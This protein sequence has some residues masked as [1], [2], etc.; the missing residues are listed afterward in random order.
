MATKATKTHLLEPA[1]TPS[2]GP[3]QQLDFTITVTPRVVDLCGAQKDDNS[4]PQ[5]LSSASVSQLSIHLSASKLQ[6]I[7]TFVEVLIKKSPD[8][9]ETPDLTSGALSTEDEIAN[10]SYFVRTLM[11]EA[12]ATEAIG[13]TTGENASQGFWAAVKAAARYV[14][15]Q[16]IQD[17]GGMIEG[18]ADYFR[19]VFQSVGGLAYAGYRGVMIPADIQKIDTS[20][21]A[22]TPLGQSAYILG[23]IGNIAFL[24]FYLAIG[25]WSGYSLTE[26]FRFSAAMK[27]QEKTG[28]LFD[29]FM[30]KVT[31]DPKTKLQ[32][33]GAD[34][35]Q[36]T[37]FKDKLADVALS[38]FANQFLKWQDE[39]IKEGKLKEKP[40]TEQQVK[41]VFKE[42]FKLQEAELRNQ[43]VHTTYLKA[44]G[45]DNNNLGDLNFT[46]LELIG[47]KLEQIR[48]QA[49]KEV[50]FS[51]A[52]NGDCVEA[53]KKAAKRGLGERL[54]CN[55]DA[56]KQA[57]QTEL[58]GLKGKVVSENTKNKWIHSILIVVAITGI[59]SSIMGM[60]A[61]NPIGI[62]AMTVITLI[63]VI[64]M[65]ITDGSSMVDG[66]KT[67]QAPGRYDKAYIIGISIVLVIAIAVSIGLTLGL[68]LPILPMIL[69]CGIGG[70][71]LG[72]SGFSYYKLIQKEKAWIENHPDLQKFQELL[73]SAQGSDLDEKVT[74]VFKK[75]P[76][77]DRLAI[78]AKYNEL[79]ANKQQHE[80]KNLEYKELDKDGNFGEQYLKAQIRWI[81]FKWQ[82]PDQSKLTVR[83]MKKTVKAY[84]E[85]WEQ[86]K[87]KT[88]L[89]RVLKLQSLFERIKQ[90]NLRNDFQEKFEAMQKDT[91]MYDQLKNDIWYVVKRQESVADLQHVVGEVIKDKAQTILTEPVH[92]EDRKEIPPLFQRVIKAFSPEPNSVDQ[93]EVV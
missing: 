78:R 21:K 92:N 1:R 41:E 45:L 59:V 3:A 67:G 79:S 2:L 54:K 17:R 76:K 77:E 84:W 82:T 4:S 52:T 22:A 49:K 18:G 38:K 74:A 15:A 9:G 27:A 6:S 33:L 39:L 19:G 69:A 75:L 42:L 62:I 8:S 93:P 88:D 26:D 61:L 81:S 71:G 44:L 7:S 85:K 29:F 90:Q 36:V 43:G 65:L 11:P 24:L 50:K 66:W 70:A 83:A 46:T 56:V 28:H 23:M 32:K 60:L 47:F 30:R 86:S 68:G 57:A 80:F 25:V 87:E 16:S 48:S 55:D 91:E 63:L 58:E 13:I 72:L 10:I 37:A 12:V 40:L 5:A 31:A 73:N 89:Q 53:V 34:E 20:I 64:G 51:R 35:T 14:K